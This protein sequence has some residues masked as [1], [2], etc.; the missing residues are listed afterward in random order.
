MP[1]VF[2]TGTDTG[3]GK[4]RV[5]A[6]LIAAMARDGQRV[7]G[8]K[9]V[10]AGLSPGVADNED[11]LALAQASNVAAPRQARCPYMFAAAVAPHV[12]AARDGITIE[13][14]R[15]IEAYRA[16]AGRAD[17]VVVEGAGG[18]LAPLGERSDLLD[19]AQAL[20]LPVVLVVG[21]RL[22]CL[23]HARLTAEAV[24]ARRLRFAGWIANAIDPDMVER[25]ANVRYLLDHLPGPMLASF[26]WQPAGATEC[27][28][29]GDSLWRS[30]RN[31]MGVM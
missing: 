7:L 3:V 11:V 14:K 21:L 30:L 10:A 29:P 1:G 28:D 22:G 13:L 5:A 9:P 2:V 8:M 24:V 19:F 20:A 4:T 12:A 27:P 26:A 23:N 25:E 17:W 18:A 6:A 31:A 15:L 16:L